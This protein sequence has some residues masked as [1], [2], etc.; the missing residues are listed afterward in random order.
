MEVS[1]G[2]SCARLVS[3]LS[4]RLTG[5][6]GQMSWQLT[7]N[8]DPK[9]PRLFTYVGHFAADVQRSCPSPIYVLPPWPHLG[10][11]TG[12]RPIVV[13]KVE[14]NCPPSRVALRTSPVPS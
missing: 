1:E 8:R 12:A 7:S 4:L 14:V 13:A 3:Y 2:S 5:R 11:P 9:K 10:E 6:L